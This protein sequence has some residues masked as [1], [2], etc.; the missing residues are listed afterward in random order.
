MSRWA[1]EAVQ[2]Q[3]GQVTASVRKMLKRARLDDLDG[4][5]RTRKALWRCGAAGVITVDRYK[6]LDATLEDVMTFYGEQA[7]PQ[8]PSYRVVL[9]DFSRPDPEASKAP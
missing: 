6:A 8:A 4:V 2:A 3:R 9:Q 5:L 7:P 1:S